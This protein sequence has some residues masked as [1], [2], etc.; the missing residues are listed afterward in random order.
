MV[1]NN[2][3]RKGD[4]RQDQQRAFLPINDNFYRALLDD[5]ITFVAVLDSEGIILF[6]NNSPLTV[7]GLK[8]EDVIGKKFCDSA[9]F[10]EIREVIKYDIEQCAA[11]KKTMREIQYIAYDGSKKWM[12]YSTHPIFDEQGNVQYLIQEGRDIT[13]SKQKEELLRRS[14]KMEALGKLTGGI[15]HDYNNMLC[16]IKGFTDLLNN[17][18]PDDSAL[19]N[20]TQQ[21]QRATERGIDL[22]RKLLTFTRQKSSQKQAVNINDQLL[23]LQ[24]LLQKTLTSKIIL[25]YDLADELWATELNP[26][27]L[28]DVIVNI[29]INAMHAMES[30]GHLSIQT[31]NKHFNDNELQ[32][33]HLQ[34]VPGDYILLSISD[35]GCGMDNKTMEKI[36]D[37]FFST[38]E[39]KGTGLGLSQALNF[40]KKL[41]GEI[42]VFSDLG[43]GTRFVLYFPGSQQA[44]TEKQTK[45][46]GSTHNLQGS[47]TILVVD[48]EPSILE[49]AYEIL[50]AKGYQVL[51][52]SDGLQALTILKKAS[53]NLI[54]SDVI[55]PH[56]DG[57]QLAA[58]VQ[59]HYPH[60]KIQIAS[61]YESDRYKV[62]Q[63][64]TLQQNILYK[65]Y[66]AFDLLVHVRD[67]L[68]E[69]S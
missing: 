30:G 12:E 32:H 28:E 1:I 39:D 31:G 29:C 62:M 19:K 27:D 46:E 51:T 5:M 15:A 35:T 34:L 52:A 54:V 48:D 47:E 56:M 61:G 64:D 58:H 2:D 3:R 22:T 49:L 53:V 41:G 45:V 69:K 42:E 26:G 57:Y 65:P 4:R 16:V 68:D 18:L 43:H 63:D 67:L 37:P 6:I 66:N 21:I 23:E 24:H 14:Q 33:H 11:G 7:G 8:L 13:K 38:K 36:F 50:S 55:M 20:Y 59:H 10:T 25:H 44:I 40:V 60:I 9:C 17:N